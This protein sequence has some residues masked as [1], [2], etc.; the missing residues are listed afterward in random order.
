M[1]S[2][3][4]VHEITKILENMYSVPSF[5]VSKELEDLRTRLTAVY[6]KEISKLA[7]CQQLWL[8]SDLNSDSFETEKELEIINYFK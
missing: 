6:F 3:F 7:N 2:E 8:D 4:K 5:T 1:N